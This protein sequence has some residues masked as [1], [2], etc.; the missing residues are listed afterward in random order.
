MPVRLESA[1]VARRTGR[2]LGTVYN[3][4]RVLKVPDGRAKKGRRPGDETEAP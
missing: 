2:G 3:R 1:E 4:R